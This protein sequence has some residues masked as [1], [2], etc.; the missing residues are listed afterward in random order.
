MSKTFVGFALLATNQNNNNGENLNYRL[1]KNYVICYI[2]QMEIRVSAHGGVC[3]ARL[4]TE[5]GHLSWIFKT[6]PE[7]QMT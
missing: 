5:N 7:L 3:G 2:F 6:P 4:L 1:F